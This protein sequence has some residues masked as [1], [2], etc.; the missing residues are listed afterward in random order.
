MKKGKITMAKNLRIYPCESQIML[1]NKGNR[2]IKAEISAVCIR[3]SHIRYEATWWADGKKHEI[4]VA[5]HE[6]TILKKTVASKIALGFKN[7]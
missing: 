7:D 4:W 5:E 3:P 2:S 6:F 1:G